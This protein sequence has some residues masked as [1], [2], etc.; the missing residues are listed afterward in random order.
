VLEAFGTAAATAMVLCYALEERGLGFTFGFAISCAAASAYAFA[1][2][3]WPFCVLEGL[4]S[5]VAL[6]RAMRGRAGTP[7]P[8]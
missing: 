3:S 8:R 7:N 1:I 2:A 4:W 5:V 6:R